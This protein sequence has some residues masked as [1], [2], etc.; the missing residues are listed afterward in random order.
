[1]R[2]G[3]DS[4]RPWRSSFDH[5]AGMGVTIPRFRHG[6]FEIARICDS[7]MMGIGLG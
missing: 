2:F 3:I 5:I 7:S 1:M 6:G 4:G